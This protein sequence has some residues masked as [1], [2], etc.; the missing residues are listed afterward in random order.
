MTYVPTRF[1]R[2]AVDSV[3][4]RERDKL[5]VRLLRDTLSRNTSCHR[6]I[7]NKNQDTII[8]ITEF[9][10]HNCQAFRGGIRPRM[11]KYDR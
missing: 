6:I 9:V 3:Q 4:K 1:C 2:H 8:L 5:E 10:P 11:D 7:D